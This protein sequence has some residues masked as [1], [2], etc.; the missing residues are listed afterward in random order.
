MKINPEERFTIDDIR[1]HP[2]FSRPNPYL[3]ETG[4]CANP[5]ILATSLLENLHVSFGNGVQSP[6]SDYE[7]EMDTS[8]SFTQP[9]PASRAVLPP[10]AFSSSQ[11][12]KTSHLFEILADEP[13]MSQFYSGKNAVS[14][15][16]TQNAQRFKD[17]CPPTSLTEFFSASPTTT[18]LSVLSEALQRV[19]VSV[20]DP[21]GDEMQGFWFRI[22]TRDARKCPMEGD[23]L[24]EHVGQNIRRVR[25]V[26]A[27]G[28]PVE[29]RR[30]FKK[31]CA[32]C[33]EVVI[34]Q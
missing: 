17:I 26:K 31:V 15:S 28:D 11:P 32:C 27:K 9:D 30:F 10:K 33:K 13:S 4:L 24:V 20:P 19:G 18:V 1:R 8:F 7:D 22:K 6:T 23:V 25:F 21:E 29:W 2:W 16:L 34:A 14:Q 5:L 12:T 3:A